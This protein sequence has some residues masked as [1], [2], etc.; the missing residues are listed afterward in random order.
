M[1]SGELILE[2]RQKGFVIALTL[3]VAYERIA[4]MPP[5]KEKREL[6]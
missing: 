2:P 6:A 1:P 4:N 5:R 3:A